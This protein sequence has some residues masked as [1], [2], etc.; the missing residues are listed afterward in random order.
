MKE[1]VLIFDC[2]GVI[3]DSNQ[4]KMKAFELVTSDSS[5]QE[6]QEFLEYVRLGFGKSRFHFFEYYLKEITKNYSKDL[7]N[8]ILKKYSDC[9]LKL[10]LSCLITDGALKFFKEDDSLKYVASGSA[11]SELREV[12]N[13]RD[14]RKYF[15]EIY[16]SPCS[17]REII[18]RII[19]SNPDGEFVMIGD[20]KSDF[21]A[22]EGLKNVHFIYMSQYSMQR[23]EFQAFEGNCIKNLGNLKTKI[24]ELFK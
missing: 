8:E 16:G 17:K 12:F 23:S 9:C 2:D 13:S 11:Q 10:Y 22:C 18:E 1:K 21:N 20:S 6:Q 19:L 14:I 15:E 7:Y 5:T 4:L 3:L 24:E